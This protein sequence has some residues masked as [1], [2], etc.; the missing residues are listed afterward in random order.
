MFEYYKKL[1]SE[2]VYE[3]GKEKNSNPELYP[4]IVV[5]VICGDL[6]YIHRFGLDQL[7]TIIECNLCKRNEENDYLRKY[8]FISFC[9]KL[10]NIYFP[11]RT[12][13]ENV[14]FSEFLNELVG[15]NK[16]V[17]EFEYLKKEILEKLNSMDRVAYSQHTDPLELSDVSGQIKAYTFVLSM[18]N[19]LKKD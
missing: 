10:H 4:Y 19:K 15:F 7:Q 14:V 6:T 8:S 18:I 12:K 1:Y 11:N 16:Q 13:E 9:C 17:S 5:K 3:I 2:A